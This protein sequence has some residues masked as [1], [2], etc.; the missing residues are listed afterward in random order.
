MIGHSRWFDLVTLEYSAIAAF[1]LKKMWAIRSGDF[2]DAV[3]ASLRLRDC[4]EIS[5]R[6]TK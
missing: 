3:G 1:N 5:R 4:L 6:E 2:G